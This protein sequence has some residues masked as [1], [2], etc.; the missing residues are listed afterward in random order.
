MLTS[1][2]VAATVCFAIWRLAG[3]PPLQ[4]WHPEAL[5][6]LD[7]AAHRLVRMVLENLAKGLVR[8][9]LKD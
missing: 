5:E 8:L 9:G 2:R 6:C 1:Y 3:D 7:S 4:S